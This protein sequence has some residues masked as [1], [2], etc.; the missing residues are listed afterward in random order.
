[1]QRLR[2]TCG[3]PSQPTGVPGGCR[4]LGEP[5]WSGQA[6][7]LA[8]RAVLLRLGTAGWHC[9][10]RGSN[11]AAAREAG[12]PVQPKSTGGPGM[13]MLLYSAPALPALNQDPP[14]ASWPCVLHTQ[15]STRELSD[16][17]V[18]FLLTVLACIHEPWPPP[19]RFLQAQQS[20]QG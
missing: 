16:P 5:A 9:G 15:Q 12:R 20:T 1:M 19:T 6:V 17:A 7:W 8:G 10:R 13:N 3:A 4:G 11:V 18:H 14:P 2:L